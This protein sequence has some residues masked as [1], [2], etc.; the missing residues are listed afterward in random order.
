MKENQA[1]S[2][3]LGGS[4]GGFAALAVSFL[5]MPVDG[6]GILPGILFW[7]GLLIGVALQIALETRRRALFAKYSVK[8]ETMQKPRNGLLS[9]CS[10]LFATVADG[11]LAVG[12]VALVPVF[13]FTKGMGYL[14]YVN[15]SVVVG[16]FCA[17]C[18]FNGR[19]YVFVKNEAKVRQA[20]EQK[21]ANSNSKGEGKK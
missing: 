2:L 11:L 1:N 9:V 5:L 16:S 10:N 13:V 3:L 14:C 4:L 18:V 17:H 15:L 21:K 7:A 12:V 8:R 20:L 6:L 19:N